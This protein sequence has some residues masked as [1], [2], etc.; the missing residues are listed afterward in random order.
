MKLD[1]LWFSDIK[2]EPN[3][4]LTEY[5]PIIKYN[6]AFQKIQNILNRFGENFVINNEDLFIRG[7]CILKINH[8]L[9]GKKMVI[10][11]RMT[12]SNG[13]LL[14][15]SLLL[16][17]RKT[18]SNKFSPIFLKKYLRQIMKIDSEIS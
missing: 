7:S 2:I 13:G 5:L 17:E 16:P 9:N 8:W 14:N 10:I 1:P 12:E 4:D 6:L 3:V 15:I 18:Q 11:L